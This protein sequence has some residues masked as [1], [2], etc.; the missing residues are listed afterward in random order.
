[1]KVVEG[2]KYSKDH[3]WVKVEGGIA[4]IGVSDFAQQQLT[5]VVFVELPE[6]GKQAEQGKTMGVIESVK[7]VSDVFAPV[8]G[9][10]IEVNTKLSDSPELINN[11]PYG[12][13]WI[14]KVKI[15]DKAEL[16]SL[17][18]HEEYAKTCESH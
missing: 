8:S 17:L 12:E 6:K 11:D 14:A 4:T 16:D 2:L 15:K 18:G 9:E 5:D 7:S 10:I 13:G 1:M 3:E